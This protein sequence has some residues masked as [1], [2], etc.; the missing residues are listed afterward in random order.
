MPLALEA[1]ALIQRETCNKILRFADRRRRESR[2]AGNWARGRVEEG[3]W[4][5]RV[6]APRQKP[7]GHAR[8]GFVDA[9]GTESPWWWPRRPRPRRPREQRCGTGRSSLRRRRSGWSSRG[10][11]RV[12]ERIGGQI[13]KQ[14]QCGA[15]LDHHPHPAPA[16]DRASREQ[17]YQDPPAG[18]MYTLQ[19]YNSTCCIR[20]TW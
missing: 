6:R 13:A 14:T 3:R 19:I 15:L 2:A 12:F 4:S 7:R 18:E 16:R 17:K 8:I 11:S 1:T 5:A 20:D 10:S 9:R